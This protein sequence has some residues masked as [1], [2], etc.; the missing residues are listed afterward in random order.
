VLF[1]PDAASLRLPLPP[2]PFEDRTVTTAGAPAR[3][4]FDALALRNG[5]SVADGLDFS[6]RQG[7]VAVDLLEQVAAWNSLALSP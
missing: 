2:E 3:A 7:P 1:A 6:R 5:A 4:E